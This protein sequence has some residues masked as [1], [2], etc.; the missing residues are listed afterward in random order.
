MIRGLK[1]VPLSVTFKVPSRKVSVYLGH[2]KENI[3]FIKNIFGLDS[4][5]LQ[6]DADH[7]ELVA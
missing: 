4:I 7:L 2:K 3:P 5:N 6:Q 1:Q